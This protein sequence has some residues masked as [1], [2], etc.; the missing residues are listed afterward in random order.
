M[1][2]S[3]FDWFPPCRVF[4]FPLSRRVGKIRYVALKLSRKVTD[5]HAEHYRSLVDDALRKQLVR[6]G[7]D[8]DAQDRELVAFWA[9]VRGEMTRLAYGHNEQGGEAP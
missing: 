3:L 1:Q 4:T 9:S 6:I 5:R 8:K 7:L 2:P